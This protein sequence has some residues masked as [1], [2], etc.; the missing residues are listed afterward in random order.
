DKSR[1]IPYSDIFVMDYDAYYYYGEESW[2]F[3]GE[4]EITSAIDY[5]TSE[6]LPTIYLLTGHGA[7]ALPDAFATPVETE[8]MQTQELSLL[9][10]EAV[11]DDADCL[12]IYAPQRDISLEEKTKIET[13][14]GNGGK[15]IL[16]SDPPQDGKLTNLEAIMG[17]YGI[18]ASEGIVVEGDQ[19]H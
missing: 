1:Y 7:Q 4:S 16:L 5:V 6:D 8:N 10:A 18:T 13:Y 3:C 19:S 17:H 12:L 9:T 15:L 11:P 2:S 14:L